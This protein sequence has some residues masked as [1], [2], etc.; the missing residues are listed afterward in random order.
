MSDPDA[1]G[2]KDVDLLD[3]DL[4]GKAVGVAILRKLKLRNK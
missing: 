1:R 3:W 2:I 4:E